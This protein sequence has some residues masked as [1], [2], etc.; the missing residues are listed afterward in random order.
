MISWHP[1]FPFLP[2][3]TSPPIIS[4]NPVKVHTLLSP[5]PF[6]THIVTFQTLIPSGIPLVTFSTKDT[7]EVC[8]CVCVYD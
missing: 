5:F 3:S 8:V 6:S 7:G 1:V 4:T 2:P